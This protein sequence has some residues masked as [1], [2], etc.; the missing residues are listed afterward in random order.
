MKVPVLDVVFATG[1]F[2]AGPRRP[3][4]KPCPLAR[5]RLAAALRLSAIARAT[6]LLRYAGTGAT[7]AVAIGAASAAMGQPAPPSSVSATTAQTSQL[8]TAGDEAPAWLWQASACLNLGELSA[9]GPVL[10]SRDG[11]SCSFGA[12]RLPVHQQTI[13]D[14]QSIPKAIGGRAPIRVLSS[15]G[16]SLLTSAASGVG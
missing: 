7:F 2:P 16:V 12:Q 5:E 11:N 4:G 10:S 8:S 6:C 9:G 14:L 13:A 3:G 15:R 1:P